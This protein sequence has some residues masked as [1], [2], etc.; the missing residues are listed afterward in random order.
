MTKTKLSY[1]ATK[2][3]LVGALIGMQLNS[4]EVNLSLFDD[5]FW[6]REDITTEINGVGVDKNF[7]KDTINAIFNGT[8]FDSTRF[9]DKNIAALQDSFKRLGNL[10]SKNTFVEGLFGEFGASRPAFDKFI[11][12]L[13]LATEMWENPLD[14]NVQS[15]AIKRMIQLNREYNTILI[16]DLEAEKK[17]LDQTSPDYNERLQ[18]INNEIDL[19]R[20]IMEYNAN[21]LDMAFNT[22]GHSGRNENEIA[23]AALRNISEEIKAKIFRVFGIDIASERGAQFAVDIKN[24][25][26]KNAKNVNNFTQATNTTISVANDM[27]IGSRIA[28]QNNPYNTYAAKL[29]KLKLASVASDIAPNYL[30]NTYAQSVWANVFGG[31]NIID[32]H[33]GG[34]YGISVGADKYI[35][36]SVLL[37]VYFSY[38]NST[39]KDSSFKQESDNYQ[40]GIYSNIHLDSLWELN[41]KG[42][43]QISPMDSN[44]NQTDG[45]YRGDYTSKFLG[46]SA[47]VGRKL[48]LEDTSL[49]IK[50]FVGANYYFSYIPSHTDKGLIDKKMESSKNNSLSLEVG[51]EFRKY[52]N[53]SSYFFAIPKVEQYVLNS[54]DDYNVT[55][56][57]NNAFFTQVRTD[58]KKKT[59]GGLIIGGNMNLTEQLSLNVGIGAKQILAGKVDSKNETYLIGQAGLKYKF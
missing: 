25:T 59:Y 54:S 42:Y 12:M 28:M 58:D 45:A 57:A 46:L 34:L 1:F 33:S 31:A 53:E 17:A 13:K 11:S 16:E 18:E 32:S 2:A 3:L 36:D 22:Q 37:G 21:N 48:E 9:N 20:Q 7:A 6:N 26:Q 44:Y 24:D 50:P 10:L 35:T 4:A 52:F 29:S 40:L 43:G 5:D 51:A 55:L 38:A 19:I 56:A 15:D 39:L 47:N 49:V 27:S 14:K 8:Y 41:L 23:I 30:D